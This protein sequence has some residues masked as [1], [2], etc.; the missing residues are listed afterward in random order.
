MRSFGRRFLAGILTVI[1]VISLFAGHGSETSYGALRQDGTENCGADQSADANGAGLSPGA[2]S[3]ALE[4]EASS[5]SRTDEDAGAAPEGKEPSPAADGEEKTPAAEA[6]GTSAAGKGGDAGH[7]EGTGT[8]AEPGKGGE[9]GH[10]EGA[11][12]AA[13]PGKDGAADT[14]PADGSAGGENAA[15]PA[16]EPLEKTVQPLSGTDPLTPEEQAD[17]CRELA[18]LCEAQ[19]AEETLFFDGPAETLSA[20]AFVRKLAGQG[21][22]KA[23]NA[24]GVVWIRTAGYDTTVGQNGLVGYNGWGTHA[25]LVKDSEG[26][27]NKT[28]PAICMSPN[29]SAPA[30]GQTYTTGMADIFTC[31]DPRLLKTLYYGFGGQGKDWAEQTYFDNHG[32]RSKEASL[33]LTHTAVAKIFQELFRERYQATG[34]RWDYCLEGTTYVKDTEDFLRRLDTLPEPPAGT[35]AQ[36]LWVRGN[37]QFLVYLKQGSERGRLTIHKYANDQRL[38]LD[39]DYDLETTFEIRSAATDEKVKTIRTDKNGDAGPVT[40]PAGTYYLK[41]VQAGRHMILPELQHEST[42]NIALLNKDVTA[43]VG[44]DGYGHCR[45]VIKKVNEFG[46]LLTDAS[47]VEFT[48]SVWNGSRYVEREKL[49]YDSTLERF[50]SGTIYADAANP[51][52]KF[53][54]EETCLPADYDYLSEGHEAFLAYGTV[55]EA[56]WSAKAKKEKGKTWGYIWQKT[57]ENRHEY[58]VCLRK[59]DKKTGQPVAGAEFV[60]YAVVKADG[61]LQRLGVMKYDAAERLYVY[62]R[63]ARAAGEL[64]VLVTEKNG[65]GFRVVETAPPENYSGAYKKDFTLGARTPV[66]RPYLINP[67]EAAQNPPDPAYGVI[68]V[69]KKDPYG[70]PLKGAKFLVREYDSA[71]ADYS[72]GAFQYYTEKA[73]GGLLEHTASAYYLTDN[74]DGTYTSDF[75]PILS[76]ERAA[77]VYGRR[78]DGRYKVVEVSPPEG[79]VNTMDP[80]SANVGRR[81]SKEVVF[82]TTLPANAV[83]RQSARIS[84]VNP[85]NEIPMK[86]VAADGETPLKAEFTIWTKNRELLGKTIV[87]R[88]GGQESELCLTES[89]TSAWTGDDG[90]LTFAQLP[91]GRY[92]IRETGVSS[93]W[94]EPL[95][96]VFSFTVRDDGSLDGKVSAELTVVR[97][98]PSRTLEITKT[99]TAP[100][101]G[102]F[103]TAFPE[104]TVFNVYSSIDGG[105]SYRTVPYAKII[106]RDGAFVSEKTGLPVKLRWKTNNGGKFKVVE[107]AATP[108]YI[109]DTRERFIEIPEVPQE[110][111]DGPIRL[112]FENEPNHVTIRKVDEEGSRLSGAVFRL[113]RKADGTESEGDERRLVTDESGEASAYR[114][115]PGVWRYEE[116]AAPA[117]F[118]LDPAASGEFVIGDD[119]RPE[120]EESVFTVVNY[121]EAEIVLRKKDGATG[122]EIDPASGFPSGTAFDVYEWDEALGDYKSAPLMQIVY[123]DDYQR[124]RTAGRGA[125]RDFGDAEGQTGPE[126]PAG[127]GDAVE[128][129]G[130]EDTKSA[131]GRMDGFVFQ[132]GRPL[133]IEEA[134]DWEPAEDSRGLAGAA[135]YSVSYELRGGAFPASST[136]PPTSVQVGKAFLVPI[137]RQD[138]KAFMGWKIEG[139]TEGQTHSYGQ[140][141]DGVYM[142]SNTTTADGIEQTGA[143]GFKNLAEAG[144]QVIFRARW[145]DPKLC[146][147]V[148]RLNGGSWQSGYRPP[149]EV[150]NGF[151]RYGSTYSGVLFVTRAYLN[152]PT[153]YVFDG[154]KITGLSD[155]THSKFTQGEEWRG[156]ADVARTGA[157]KLCNLNHLGG[158][159][160]FTALWKP[161]GYGITYDYKGGTGSEA[162]PDM[163]SFG[164]TFEVLPPTRDGYDFAGW[165]ITGLTADAAWTWWD[166]A[167]RAKSG[168]GVQSLSGIPGVAFKNLRT[169]G[170]AA[171]RFT[172]KWTRYT[173]TYRLKGGSWPAGASTPTGY[174][175]ASSLAVPIP[176]RVGYLFAGWEE[177]G[178]SDVV[179]GNGQ[180]GNAVLTALWR[181]EGIWVNGKDGSAPVVAR[182]ENN[183]GKFK[184]VE[185][186]ATPGYIRDKEPRYF[187][188]PAGQEADGHRVELSFVNQP[189]EYHIYKADPEGLRINGAVFRFYCEDPSVSAPH[190]I[191]N[192]TTGPYNGEEGAIFLRRIPTGIWHFK[193]VSVPSPYIANTSAEYTFVVNSDGEV[194]STR[195][196]QEVPNGSGS[197]VS[198]RKVTEEGKPLKGAWFEITCEADG[199][200]LQ[201]KTDSSGTILLT[202]LANGSYAVRES[203]TLNNNLIRQG[204][205]LSDETWRVTIQGSRIQALSPGVS[206]TTAGG[207]DL[208]LITAVNRRPKLTVKKKDESGNPL[209]GARFLLTNMTNGETKSGTTGEDG[210]ILFK[211]AFSDGEW[212]AVETKAPDGPLAYRLDG[213]TETFTVENGLFSGMFEEATLTF[214]NVPYS[215]EIRKADAEGNPLP[216]TGFHVWSEDGFDLEVETT[217]LENP[218]GSPVFDEN[219]LRVA[220]AMAENL[221][222]GRYHVEEIRTPDGYRTDPRQKDVL[223]TRDGPSPARLFFVNDPLILKLR[224]IDAEGNPLAGAVFRLRYLGTESEPKDENVRE[225]VSGTDGFMEFPLP[226]LPRGSYELCETAAPEGFGL[227][228]FGIPF[229]YD[230]KT[231]TLDTAG[232]EGVSFDE[233][234]WTVTAEDPPG[235]FGLVRVRKTDRE[236]GETL[237]DAVFEAR[238]RVGVDDEGRILY[239]K[240]GQTLVWREAEESFVSDPPLPV[241]KTNA[242]CYDI[243]ELRAPDGYIRDYEEE[244]IFSEGADETEIVLQAQNTPNSFEIRKEDELGHV[245]DAWFKVWPEVGGAEE[246]TEAEQTIGGLLRLEKLSPGVWYFREVP[247]YPEGCKGDDALHS[248]TVG[249]DGNIIGEDHVVVVNQGNT[250]VYGSIR[251][252]KTDEDSRPMAGV[253]F[254]AY[255]FDASAG[256]NGAFPEKTWLMEHREETGLTDGEM[257]AL[258]TEAGAYEFAW[259]AEEKLYRS[260]QLLPLNENNRSRYL[261]V[262]EGYAD[263]PEGLANEGYA[264][265]A[266]QEVCLNPA[267]NPQ[268]AEAEFPTLRLRIYTV[269]TTLVNRKNEVR[270]LKV[271]EEGDPLEGAVF[272]VTCDQGYE[273]FPETELMTGGDGQTPPL[274]RLP[275]GS[276]TVHEIAAPPGYVLHAGTAWHFSA[277]DRGLLAETAE[278]GMVVDRD[279]DGETMDEYAETLVLQVVDEKNGVYVY[280]TD[281]EG[282]PIADVEVTFWDPRGM[283]YAVRTTGPDGRTDP[284]TGLAE[285]TWT[286]KETKKNGQ[287][288]TDIER[289]FLVSPLGVREKYGDTPML[290][291]ALTIRNGE[292]TG[293]VT[294]EKL[295]EKTR[296]R[297]HGAVFEVLPY[298][299]E[300]SDYDWN[301]PCLVLKEETGEN[302][303]LTGIYRNDTPIRADSVNGGMFLVAE[304]AGP[305]D[306]ETGRRVYAAVWEKEIDIF[307]QETWEFTT[308]SGEPAENMKTS[309][310]I[311]KVDEE[312]KLLD[313]AV[314]R[315]WPKGEEDKAVEKTTGADGET[316]AILLGGLDPA[317]ATPLLSGTVYCFKEISP[318]P[319]AYAADG[320]VHSF[321]VAED[322]TILGA[323]SG[324]VK[325]INRQ[326]SARLYAGGEGRLPGLLAGCLGLLMLTLS[327]ALQAWAEAK[328][329]RRRE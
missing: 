75:L 33:I 226:G 64:P 203:R 241:T 58:T 196:Y 69:T 278:D 311:E 104:G 260:I 204:F 304:T 290:I 147:I 89:G 117:G 43:E 114:L 36:I 197:S 320:K 38:F 146:R 168:T 266:R 19:G 201:K 27:E 255:P 160:T 62:G 254:R 120:T 270:I 224:K 66:D 258:L 312:G 16:E 9:T 22:A 31:E 112:S 206:V 281:A 207:S 60:V 183:R 180:T 277:D 247:P 329:G 242:G 186:S 44:N 134:A 116:T 181:T 173:V 228:P 86:K 157:Q 292:K 309:Y 57:V 21:D 7:D 2:E 233:A 113:S 214:T 79:Y 285:G 293:H 300:Q 174:T 102:D 47:G 319:G 236:T 130:D 239:A 188:V 139:L 28:Y 128:S 219:G 252:R 41:E 217:L 215:F 246:E 108:G 122:A 307:E 287:P 301:H 264:A 291:L 208:A 257:A 299:P 161:I 177:R 314:F 149:T 221:S 289:H 209:A 32:V 179:L 321:E 103:S 140:Y 184:V 98:E 200:V 295:D 262:E 143:T 48:L 67:D 302:G 109:L 191:G 323:S 190:I 63:N 151:G 110:D 245:L 324:R 52:G 216:G 105:D 328:S 84:A 81:W 37:T 249:E 220:A 268:A 232:L 267:E 261:I 187:E 256:Q 225:A 100:E 107:T 135:A 50:C 296:E 142:W 164:E 94:Y 192:H 26:G 90:L 251:I 280:K 145:A 297:L 92:E 205:I 172:A 121:P 170:D 18:A 78:N 77:A 68:T 167:G 238:E 178:T 144:G 129:S 25:F 123:V 74:G 82:D 212:T 282:E 136:A 235:R 91:S 313:G 303:E 126:L 152:A 4:G 24:G 263:D 182:S 125:A 195:D 169:N 288:Y 11:G 124:G 279:G 99:D 211:E 35:Y 53:K 318:P 250:S 185:R 76:G 132:E 231:V 3:A 272:R 326:R 131:P 156:P 286:Y 61:R 51:T 71:K 138:N 14:D 202:G 133:V 13:E 83:D 159:V 244:I 106:Y 93:D 193:E 223:V 230:G 310:R 148:Y 29:L 54:L 259:D 17:I 45:V 305:L 23:E 165:D 119:G 8:A 40:L 6:P 154:W 153:G 189:N 20:E 269:E 101:A 298:D 162:N 265:N 5:A 227:L 276:Y 150:Y 111:E 73:Q 273:N 316:G 88:A 175:S 15:V 85:E 87:A 237:R 166:A 70:R 271:D 240:T 39:G 199:R 97:N 222:T 34:S 322:G 137:P 95:D 96:M 49:R 315:I 30:D 294:V 59:I 155:T 194:E 10:D 176:Q 46:K 171:V 127:F 317:G 80:D 72:K 213:H 325:V 229:S 284:L 275:S 283:L 141:E 198:I 65:G 55:G 248:F 42:D 274:R 327:A 1:L 210:T 308:G 158:T 56:R 115:R 234:E 218:D 163:A 253:I 306:P 12:T 118:H 243:V